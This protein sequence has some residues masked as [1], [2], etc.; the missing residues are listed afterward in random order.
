MPILDLLGR[1]VKI[2]PATGGAV[3]E[4]QHPDQE[5]IEDKVINK[6]A[7]KVTAFHETPEPDISNIYR[8]TSPLSRQDNHLF[9][10]FIDGSIRTY[11]LATGIEGPRSFPIELAQVGAAVIQREQDGEVKVWEHRQKILLLLPKQNEG[12][13]DTLWIQLHRVEKPEFLELVD[14]TLP[15]TLSN[16]R[17]DPRD[18]AGAKARFEMHKLEIEL[19][20]TTDSLRNEDSWLVL[21]GAVKLDEF[22]QAPNLIGVAKSFRKD[23]Y[24]QFGSKSRERKDITSILAGLPHAHRTAAFSA[25]GGKVAFWYV[26]LREQRELDYPLMGVVKVELPRPDQTPIPA[27]LADLLSRALVAE[28]NVTPYGL[29]RRWHCSLYPIHIAEQVIKNKFFSR[30]VLMGCI[31]W[32]RP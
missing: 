7:D 19:I 2:L 27:E 4:L 8:P 21:D 18:K 13:S 30:E 31:K 24:F 14:F 12:I 15:D 20:E 23:P 9:R 25:Y 6:E 5:E 22:I 26:R 28:R 29:D 11:F 17:T 10:F 3:E 32:P 1:E 16:T